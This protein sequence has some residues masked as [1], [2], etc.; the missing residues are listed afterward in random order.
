MHI[1][2]KTSLSAIAM[3][4]ACCVAPAAYAQAVHIEIDPQPLASALNRVAVQTRSQILFSPDMVAGRTA[5]KVRGSMTVDGALDRLLQ[6]T[7]LRYRHQNNV[8]LIERPEGF[9][10][11]SSDTT[12]APAQAPAIDTAPATATATASEPADRGAGQLAEIIVTAQKREESLQGTPISIAVLGADDLEKRG[13]ATLSDFSSGAIPSLRIIPFTGRPSALNITMRGINPGDATQ[14]SRDATVGLYLDG[15]YLGRTQGLGAE[16]FDLERIE[17]LRGPQGTLFGRNAVGGAIS[18]VSKRPTGKLG[19]DLTAGISNF[20]GRSIKAHLNLPEFAGFSIKLDG[21][22]KKRDGWV[23]NPLA[24]ASDWYEVNRRGARVSVL[25]EPAPNL[26]FLYSYDISRDASTSGYAQME[27]LPDAP[28]FPAILVSEDKRVRKGQIGVPLR[29]SL[30]KVSGHGLQAKWEI[31]DNL[32]LRSISAYR[33][34]AQEHHANNG[35]M[36]VAYAS[37]GVFSR[38][39]YADVHQ[40]QFSQEIQF[41]GSYEHLK[42]ILGGFYFEED[43]DDLAHAPFT[44]RFNTDG[45]G[46]TL[47]PFALS[48]PGFPERA[49]EA[50]ARSKAI[51]GQLTYTPPIFDERLHLT[52]G[53]RW[54]H[55]RKHGSLTRARGAVIDVPFKFSSKR[56]DPAFTAAFDWTDSINTYV[57]WGTAYRAGGANSRSVTFRPFGDEEVSSWEIGAKTELFDRRARFNIAAFHTRY[58]DRQVTFPNPA[59]PSSNETVNAED[60]AIIKGIEVDL[61]ARVAPGLTLSGSYA[62]TDWKAS[63]DYNPVL[64]VSQQGA[65]TYTPKHS[66]SLSLDHELPLFD[67]VTLASHVDVVHSGSFY[68]QG[69]N[70]PKT[71]AYTM[72]NGRLTIGGF[73]VGNSGAKLA[74][75]LWSKNLTNK[76]WRVYQFNIVGPGLSDVTTVIWNEPRTFG[77][78]AQLTF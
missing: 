32:T 1:S 30:G 65:I 25:W 19:L 5:R 60:P 63:T 69:L 4:V 28:I 73:D 42:F 2:H 46:Y 3:A 27:R 67:D 78:D 31:T 8:I 26:E 6:D 72:I 43:A 55:D 24:G 47:V 53:L 39:S 18:M 61:M 71:D 58:R 37:N 12:P 34:M 10:R 33:K 52:A 15:V 70:H 59:N 35:D 74:I 66:V 40:D 13:V 77:L 29:P 62:Y 22:W 23:D 9:S 41:L 36:L 68:S 14:I 11:I 76:A 51:F 44:A 48:G 64:G 21:V 16:M 20:S 54:T 49:S 50:H 45:T 57:K 17:V 38:Y 7:G 56:F 75:S